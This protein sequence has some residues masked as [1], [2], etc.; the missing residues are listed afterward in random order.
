MTEG[1]CGDPREACWAGIGPS[2]FPLPQ[3]GEGNKK[4]TRPG[5]F[6]IET[7]PRPFR[8][9]RDRVRAVSLFVAEVRS[10]NHFLE[11]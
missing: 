7:F 8:W 10:R 4:Q 6:T 1:A 5:L 2:P 9:E 3:A 11:C